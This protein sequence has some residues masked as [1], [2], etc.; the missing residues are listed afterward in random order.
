MATVHLSVLRCSHRGLNCYSNPVLHAGG[1]VV[2]M[3][4][5]DPG[6]ALR[7]IGTEHITRFFGVPAPYQFMLQHPS[8]P[9]P[10]LSRL[11]GAGVGGAPA[12]CRFLKAGQR[13]ASS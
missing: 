13:A 9:P 10:A 4:T 1:T 6:H 5:F 12:R 11:Q 3:R 2:I 7:V 8:S